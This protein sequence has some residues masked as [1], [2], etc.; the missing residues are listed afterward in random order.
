VD[1]LTS[2]QAGVD[3]AIGSLGTSCSAAQLE[4]VFALGSRLVF[5]FDGDAAGRAAAHRA[6]ATVL[7]LATDERSIAFAVLPDGHDPDCHASAYSGHGG[8]GINRPARSRHK[9]ATAESP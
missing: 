7:P 3:G 2:V 8:V 4:R 6:L 1:V 5:C 9:P